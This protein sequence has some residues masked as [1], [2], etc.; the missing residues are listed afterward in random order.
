MNFLE[1]SVATFAQPAL[2]PGTHRSCLRRP[3]DGPRSVAVPPSPTLSPRHQQLRPKSGDRDEL[4][5]QRLPVVANGFGSRM[6]VAHCSLYEIERRA[7]GESDAK[8]NSPGYNFDP[9]NLRHA[10]RKHVCDWLGGEQTNDE[11]RVVQRA[12][13]KIAWITADAKGS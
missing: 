3:K 12:F 10:Q 2:A 1:G 13:W 8:L 6:R 11:K 7:A 4:A 5:I 9:Y